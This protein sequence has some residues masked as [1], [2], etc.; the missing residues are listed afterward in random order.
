MPRVVIIGGG[1]GGLSAAR[2]LRKRAPEADC[3]LIDRKETTDFL[4]MLP[5]LLSRRVGAELLCRDLAALA[6]RIGFQFLHASVTSVD[7]KR[8]LVRT[9]AGPVEYD[10]LIIAGG[11]ETDFHGRDD[12]REAAFTLDSVAD[13]LA[14]ANAVETD[15]FD[16]VVVAGGGYTGVE[17]A[18][19]LRRYFAKHAVE[20]RILLVEYGA[21]LVGSLETW[22]RDY[23]GR[24]LR[25]MDIDVALGA[26]VDRVESGAVHLTDGRTVERAILVWTAGVRAVDFVQKLDAE[27]CPRGRLEVDEFLRVNASCF[28]AGD[29]ACVMHR[30]RPMRMAVQI[31]LDEGA[32]AGENVARLIR[33][34]RLR[35]YRPRDL[36]WV[37]PMANDRS[38]GRALG[39]GVRGV[40]ATALHYLM[41]ILRTRGL[42]RKTAL[43]ADLLSRRR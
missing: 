39:F 34:R 11:S 16:A 35:R 26:S 23:V 38:C 19:N 22:M 17:T 21:S 33:G 31:S 13:A 7:L 29:A 28:A 18:T 37:V 20:K 25:A 43:V 5:D 24:N 2:R 27:K 42:A 10:Y 15:D 41:C 12:L 4:P 32:C 14:L 30:D 40:A 36:G 9:G 8:K 1:F 6:S 3:T